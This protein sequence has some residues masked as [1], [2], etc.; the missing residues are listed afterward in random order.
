MIDKTISDAKL[1]DFVSHN[2]D[3]SLVALEESREI[4]FS[5]KRVFYV[6]NVKTLELRGNH[7][8]YKTEQVLVCLNGK[9]TVKLDDGKNIQEYILDNPSKGLY[10]PNGVWDAQAY[11][12]Q[13]SILLS[14]CNTLYNKEDY[15]EDYEEFVKLKSGKSESN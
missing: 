12:T 13:D 4:P 10:I 7:A 6:N 5:V 15:I 2:D 9:I 8:H 11:H 1:I 14:L 3:G